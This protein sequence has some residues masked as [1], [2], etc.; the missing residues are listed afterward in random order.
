MR[1]NPFNVLVCLSFR[2]HIEVTTRQSLPFPILSPHHEYHDQPIISDRNVS[3][4][5]DLKTY[6]LGRPFV[7]SGHNAYTY[8]SSRASKNNLKARDGTSGISDGSRGASGMALKS[9]RYP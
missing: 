4:C 7:R 2:I 5:S 3:S 9:Q 8:R 1:A 6:W